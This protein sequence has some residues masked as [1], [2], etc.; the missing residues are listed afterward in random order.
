VSERA[1]DLIDRHDVDAEL[2]EALLWRYGGDVETPDPESLDSAGERVYEFMT[3]HG[4]SVR[5]AADHFYQFENHPE[6]GSRPDAPATEPDFEIVL[7]ELVE[8][9]LIA[10]TDD[11]LPRY[12]ASFHD[13][14]VDVGPSFTAGEIDALCER[15]GMDKRAVYHSIL[16]SLELDFDL[17]G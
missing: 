9:G 13:V 15:S 5:T 8:A 11:D 14:L 12:S 16:G 4:S 1:H 10:R 17:G 7:D 2:I 6:Y 3:E